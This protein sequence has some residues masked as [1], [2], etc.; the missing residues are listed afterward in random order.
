L[1]KPFSDGTINTILAEDGKTAQKG[2]P[3]IAIEEPYSICDSLGSIP[4]F[5]ELILSIL[6]R[7][8]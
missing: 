2:W 1:K 3:L 8:K 5:D 7:Y 6:L 4:I